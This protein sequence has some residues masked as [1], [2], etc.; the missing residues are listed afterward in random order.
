MNSEDLKHVWIE[1]TIRRLPKLPTL[2]V[3]LGV[4]ESQNAR[5][6][7][8]QF[9][10]RYCISTTFPVM[11]APA[12][13]VIGVVSGTD[14]Q[15]FLDEQIVRRL[16][17]DHDAV[18]TAS[19]NARLE[20]LTMARENSRIG[21]KPVPLSLEH[22][23]VLCISKIAPQGALRYQLSIIKGRKPESLIL[24]SPYSADCAGLNKSGVIQALIP[25]DTELGPCQ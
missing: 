3:G 13:T 15:C 16:R 1:L 24:L 12:N 4:E 23:V 18:Q 6:W 8:Q 11:A 2:V 21:V 14:D 5:Y 10:I 20:A 25:I 17:L 9:G 7:A 19:Q 22:E